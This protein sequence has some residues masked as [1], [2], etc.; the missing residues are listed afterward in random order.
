MTNAP[1]AGWY[2][3]PTGRFASRYWDGQQWTNHVSSG[4]ANAVDEPPSDMRFV[5]PAPGTES[6]SPAPPAA[7]QITQQPR[8]SPVGT[9]IAV[10]LGAIAILI[11]VAVLANQSSDGGSTD[12]PAEPPATT[13]APSEGSS[14]DG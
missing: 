8:R 6:T 2:G 4:G 1:S 5:A 12:A 14:G 13:Q 7:V 10:V 9:V 11:V 3:D